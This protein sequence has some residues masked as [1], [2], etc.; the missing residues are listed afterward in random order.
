[1]PLAAA[2]GP[3][4]SSVSIY[5][6]PDTLSNP[7]AQKA[8]VCWTPLFPVTPPQ[9]QDLSRLLSALT[10]PPSP[11]PPSTPRLQ[12]LPSPP[13]RDLWTPHFFL[14]PLPGQA[15]SL[16][17]SHFSTPYPSCPSDPFSSSLVNFPK[18]RLLLSLQTLEIRSTEQRMTFKKLVSFLCPWEH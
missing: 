16:S 5:R 8:P 9:G 12:A 4:G 1:M 15:P 11:T 7:G 14:L 13:P 18:S 2:T 10:S 3:Q 6:C 17:P